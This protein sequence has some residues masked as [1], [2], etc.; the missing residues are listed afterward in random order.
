VLEGVSLAGGWVP[1][2]G[3]VVGRDVEVLHDPFDPCWDAIDA[4]AAGE[5]HGDL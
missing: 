1:E 2:D 3:V 4:L 5:N